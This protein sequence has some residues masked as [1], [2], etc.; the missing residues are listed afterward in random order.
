MKTLYELAKLNNKHRR[1]IDSLM[2][3]TEDSPLK[4]LCEITFSEEELEDNECMFAIYGKKNISAFSRLKTRLKDILLQAFILQHNNLEPMDSRTN[5]SIIGYRHAFVARLLT[6]RRSSLGIDMT[7]KAIVKSMKYHSAESVLFQARI[8]VSY[9]GQAEYNKYKF[10]KYSAIQEKY[11][12]YYNWEVKAERYYAELQ[13]GQLQSLANPS[14][15][16]IERAR[17]YTEEL[18]SIIDIRTFNFLLNKYKVKS[19]YLEYTKDYKALLELSEKTYKDF[20][21]PEY[22]SNVNLAVINLRRVY[23]LIQAAR[24]NDVISFGNK[25]LNKLMNGSLG[26]YLI[27][28]YTLKAQLY[29]GNYK[30]AVELIAQMLENP[31]FPK[32]QENFK[33]IFYTTLGYINLIVDSGLAG[34]PKD[35]HKKLPE[36]KLGK[37]LNTTP[38][39]SKDKRGINVSILLMHIAFLLQRKDYNAIIDRIDSLNQYA[40]RYLRK[41]DSFRSNCMIKMVIQMTKADFNP[42]RTERYTADLRKQLGHVTL[43]GS[44]ENIEVEIIPF[45]VLWDIMVKAL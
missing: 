6:I 29:S 7:E 22:R 17:K 32:V 45:E 12:Y 20:S 4:K 21:I 34:D 27:A 9:F 19:A 33:E 23:A 37:F 25:D 30:N 31:R 28:H 35:L 10:H 16:T 11:F 26:W 38:V 3:L 42:I 5:E 8:L 1:V 14:E 18:E 2:P 44:G 40:Y 39:F 43:A 36:F 15:D 24:Y 41:D 13:R